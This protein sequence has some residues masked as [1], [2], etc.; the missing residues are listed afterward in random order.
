MFTSH[1]VARMSNSLFSSNYFSYARGFITSVV[2]EAWEPYLT[3][4]QGT[5]VDRPDLLEVIKNPFRSFTDKDLIQQFVLQRKMYGLCLINLIQSE[6]GTLEQQIINGAAIREIK[7]ID[8]KRVAAVAQSNGEDKLIHLDEDPREDILVGALSVNQNILSGW[9]SDSI[10]KDNVPARIQMLIDTEIALQSSGYSLATEISDPR[11]AYLF[12][13][14]EDEKRFSNQ[15]EDMKGGVA[16]NVCLTNAEVQTLSSN[17]A[18]KDLIEF[19]DYVKRAILESFGIDNSV[20][21]ITSAA[22]KVLYDAVITNFYASTIDPEL[23]AYVDL[24]NRDINDIFGITDGYELRFRD[25]LPENI[26][27]V[28]ERLARLVNSNIFRPNDAREELNKEP[29]E[30]GNMLRDSGPMF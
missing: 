19:S 10:P 2:G 8:G 11:N 14:N 30:E 18:P 17:T 22:S 3:D 27:E 28:S 1:Q 26:N 24:W 16:S 29:V 12:T 25:T 9:D 13:N 7:I 21:E 5:E 4:R 23:Q 15:L 6:N 20:Y